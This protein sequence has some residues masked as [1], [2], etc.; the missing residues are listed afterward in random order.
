MFGSST[1]KAGMPRPSELFLRV[2]LASALVIGSLHMIARPIAAGLLPVFQDEIELLAPVFT[3]R[4]SLIVLNGVSQSV[5][6]GAFLSSPIHLQGQVLSPLGSPGTDPGSIQNITLSLSD[7]FKYCPLPLILVI[8]WPTAG[9]KEFML[10]CALA[11]PLVAMLLLIDAPS[12][13]L[14]NLWNGVRN[15]LG[16]HGMSGWVLFRRCLSG[17]GGLV[18][19]CFMAGLAIGAAKSLIAWR[20]KKT[21]DPA[22]RV[23]SIGQMPK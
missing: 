21:R 7:V 16:V 19:G 14:A 12:V 6:F 9:V 3:I 8:A 17:G 22:Y 15:E 23:Y 10:R 20:R 11:L 18:L 1:L 5:R 4:P 13:V 2:A